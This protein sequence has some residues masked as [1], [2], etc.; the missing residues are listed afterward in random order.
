[1]NSILAIL[2]A[3]TVFSTPIAAKAE[4]I[5]T[6]TQTFDQKVDALSRLFNVKPTLAKAIISCEG[7]ASATSTNINTN[8]SVDIGPWQ[9]NSSNWP[10]AKKRGLDV[11]KI[12]DNIL[13][14]FLMMSDGG[15]HPWSASKFC[16]SKKLAD[17]S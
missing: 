1:M 14:G 3:A 4:P 6:T 5:A 2:V 7:G 16:W 8:G 17:S 9:I 10:D 15:T 11:S 13:Y 12:D